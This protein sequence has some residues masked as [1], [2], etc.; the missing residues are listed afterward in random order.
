MAEDPPLVRVA[1]GYILEECMRNTGGNVEKAQKSLTEFILGK[2][3]YEECEVDMT[4]TIHS[5]IP[6]QK[7]QKIIAVSKE[8]PRPKEYIHPL[9]PKMPGNCR[10][11]ARMWTQEEDIRLLAGI[12]RYGLGR[13]NEIVDFVG[14]GRT[15]PQCTQRWNR[16][17]DPKISKTIW[18]DEENKNLYNLVIKHGETQW[19]KIAEEMKTRSDVQCRYHYFQMKRSICSQP[20]PI[21]HDIPKEVFSNNP[22]PIETISD[23]FTVHSIEKSEPISIWDPFSITKSI[24]FGMNDSVYDENY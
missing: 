7:I 13:W 22:K 3:S 18:S 23:P 5:I 11:K 9:D 14:L 24:E 10:R 6:L 21:F 8:E 15:R 2:Q 20:V 4:Q 19:S 17:L 1:H 12:Y 16:G